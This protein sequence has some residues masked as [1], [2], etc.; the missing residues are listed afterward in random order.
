MK[1]SLIGSPVPPNLIKVTLTTATTLP[2]K[3]EDKLGK[4]F[5]VRALDIATDRLLL[6]RMYCAFMPRRAAQGLPPETEYGIARWLDRVLKSGEHFVVEVDGAV[7]GHAMLMPVENDDHARELANFLHQNI[8]GRGIG[9]ALNK[10]AVQKAREAGL[11][12][13]WLSV[14]PSNVPAIKSYRKAGFEPMTRTMFA[15]EIEMQ[16]VLA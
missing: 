15:P 10:L 9:T 14:E 12:R 16:I 6:Q 3:L 13:I 4:N 11:R 2:A 8:R 7:C 5:S 1:S